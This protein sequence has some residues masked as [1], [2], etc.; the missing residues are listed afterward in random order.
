MCLAACGNLTSIELAVCK[1]FA[2]EVV[3]TWQ[4]MIWEQAQ[5]GDRAGKTRRRL[6]RGDPEMECD[7]STTAG[8]SAHHSAFRLVCN[9]LSLSLSLSGRHSHPRP[10]RNLQPRSSIAEFNM[11]YNLATILQI[12]HT[13]SGMYGL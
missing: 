10:I 13:P 6:Q 8:R 4:I 12:E 5:A 9:A 3:M 11:F 7:V 1:D 2:T